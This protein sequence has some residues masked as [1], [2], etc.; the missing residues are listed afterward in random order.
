M[1]FP[2]W[3]QKVYKQGSNATEDKETKEFYSDIAKGLSE[4]RRGAEWGPVW[5]R[6]KAKWNA[7][8][9]ILDTLL[10]KKKWSKPGAYERSK[11]T[12]RD[13]AITD[14]RRKLASVAGPDGKVSPSDYKRIKREASSKGISSDDFDILFDNFVNYSHSRDYFK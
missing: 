12:P 4:L 8:N 11:M 1:S 2:E 6:L 14:L 9:D 13:K 5:N 7:P 3:Y 10:N